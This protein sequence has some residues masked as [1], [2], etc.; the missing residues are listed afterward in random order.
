MGKASAAHFYE[1]PDSITRMS[2][3]YC[4]P[5][6]TDQQTAIVTLYAGSRTKRVFHYTGCHGAP[7][8]LKA[9]ETAIDRATQSVRWQRPNRF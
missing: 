8:G 1:M 6:I 9:L 7:S 4:T 5:M 2:L 3:R